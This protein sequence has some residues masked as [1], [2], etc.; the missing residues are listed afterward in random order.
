M[1]GRKITVLGGG[2]AGLALAFEAGKRGIAAEVREASPVLGGLARSVRSEGFAFDLG[3]HRI[4]SHSA[5]IIK[6]FM[7]LMGDRLHEVSR[8]S[9]ILLGGRFFDYPLKPAN[10]MFSL[11]PSKSVRIFSGYLKAAMSKGRPDRSFEDWIVNRFGRAL[12]DIYFKPYTEKV[13]GLPCNEISADWASQRISLLNLYDAVK[14]A[15]FKPEKTPKT[16]ASRF[17]YPAGGI[18][19]IVDEL[20]RLAA[21]QGQQIVPGSRASSIRHKAGRIESVTFQ[22]AGEIGVDHLVSTI[23]MTDLVK[24]LDPPAPAEVRSSAEALSYRAIICLFLMLDRKS[25]TKDTWIYIPDHGIPFS[26]IHEP[27]NWDPSMAPQG[28]TS[29]CLEVFCNPGDAVW[30]EN[31][32]GLFER[33]IGPLASMG[34][35]SRGEVTAHLSEKVLNAYPVF[36]VGYKENLDRVLSYLAGFKNLTLLGRTGTYSYLNMDQVVEEA[37]SAAERLSRIG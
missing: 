7:D 16:Y 17:Y 29:L 24:S 13:W 11:G 31:P 32:D 9:R 10:A 33:C 20:A 22:G 23:P 35:V 8:T 21:G 37:V 36:K 25:V 27:R 6:W 15:V 14:K 4:F 5:D 19:S 30:N 28:K 1:S 12:F 3:G 2:L 18:G 34:F 26:R